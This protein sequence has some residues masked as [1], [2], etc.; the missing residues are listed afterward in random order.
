MNLELRIFFCAVSLKIHFIVFYSARC[1]SISSSKPPAVKCPLYSSPCHTKNSCVCI[2]TSH[3]NRP[4][5]ATDKTSTS[6][7]TVIKPG[8]IVD[9]PVPG[10][11]HGGSKAAALLLTGLYFPR[12]C[13][14][15]GPTAIK[16]SW[17]TT[18][19]RHC[20]LRQPAGEHT[21]LVHTRTHI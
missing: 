13:G 12:P 5:P 4:L 10:C 3:C 2:F 7:P 18:F 19:G 1:P 14:Q 11:R 8:S 9:A 20:Q 21:L 15:L 17:N 6:W 16:Q